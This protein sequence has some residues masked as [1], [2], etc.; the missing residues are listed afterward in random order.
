MKCPV[1][2]GETKKVR[3]MYMHEEVF[4]SACQNTEC[5]HIWLP[6]EEEKRLDDAL[7]L[8]ANRSEE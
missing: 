3:E 1:C 4:T 8:R 5:G 7:A 6:S 2:D